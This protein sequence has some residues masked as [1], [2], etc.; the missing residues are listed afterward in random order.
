MN[1]TLAK[2]RLQSQKEYPVMLNPTSL[3]AASSPLRSSPPVHIH[4]TASTSSTSHA[5]S[6][7]SSSPSPTHYAATQMRGNAEQWIVNNCSTAALRTLFD[8][9][10][11]ASPKPDSIISSVNSMLKGVADKGHS[12][13]SLE[14]KLQMNDAFK[15]LATSP[16]NELLAAIASKQIRPTLLST[17]Y[18]LTLGGMLTY[19]AT[20]GTQPEISGMEPSDAPHLAKA[21]NEGK[22]ILILDS[23]NR[24]Y[25][26]GHYYILQ[27][28][29]GKIW[30]SDPAK[31]SW[32]ILDHFKIVKPNSNA[33]II[34]HKPI[35]AK[36]RHA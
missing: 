16:K 32:E 19:L 6:S 1:I 29:N 9:F 23:E 8:I 13:F 27:K 36:S 24:E 11:Y 17:D 5:S 21:L 7:S 22:P 14:Q 10:G 3:G 28:R 33:I 35:V 12:H 2:S 30:R 25:P 20:H 15:H 34:H 26:T 4:S 31:S 18:G